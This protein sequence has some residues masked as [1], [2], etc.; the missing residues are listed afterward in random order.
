MRSSACRRAVIA[1]RDEPPDPVLLIVAFALSAGLLWL[2]AGLAMAAAT[3]GATIALTLLAVGSLLAGPAA[4]WWPGQLMPATP[5]IGTGQD[6]WRLFAHIPALLLAVLAG[7]VALAIEQRRFAWAIGASA[8][9]P[10][11]AYGHAML[12]APGLLRPTMLP[13][14][15]GSGAFMLLIAAGLV[16][17][18]FNWKRA[19][20]AAAV[21]VACA[22]RCRRARMFSPRS[23]RLQPTRRSRPAPGRTCRR[24]PRCSCL[25]ACFWS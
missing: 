16:L 14:P 23:C 10:V 20:V 1:P 13:A 11:L 3:R 24:W 2:A 6:A 25:A 12:F 22:N 18:Q 15:F 17:L 4:L 7:G 8:V 9:L 21:R 19:G 5:M